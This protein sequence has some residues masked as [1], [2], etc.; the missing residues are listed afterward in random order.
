MVLAS[1]SEDLNLTF[2]EQP[3]AD[4]PTAFL[5]SSGQFYTDKNIK[6]LPWLPPVGQFAIL[7]NTPR[8]TMPFDQV[9]VPTCFIAN[10]VY[11]P[12]KNRLLVNH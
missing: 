7:A 6:L 11:Y 8:L 10:A 4:T 2:Y 3:A 1:V 12:E 5:A 9:R